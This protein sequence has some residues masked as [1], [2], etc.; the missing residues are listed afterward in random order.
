MSAQV[1]TSVAVLLGHIQVEERTHSTGSGGPYGLLIDCHIRGKAIP[2]GPSD[3]ERFPL[4][5]TGLHE[6]GEFSMRVVRK[7]VQDLRC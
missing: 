3:A 4:Y 7:P 6:N 2:S 1:V 5:E